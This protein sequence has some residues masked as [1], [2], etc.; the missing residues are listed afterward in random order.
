MACSCFTEHLS[1]PPCLTALPEGSVS[2]R[3][4]AALEQACRTKERT[5]PELTGEHGKARLVVLARGGV[6]LIP[7]TVGPSEGP[8]GA[9]SHTR[10]S[11]KGMVQAVVHCFSVLRRSGVRALSVGAPRRSGV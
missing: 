5:Y 7:Q 6:P 11:K 3:D 10:C 2:E 8:V 4:G 1:A 9:P